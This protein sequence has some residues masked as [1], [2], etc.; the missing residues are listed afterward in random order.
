MQK[1]LAFFCLRCGV[2]AKPLRGSGALES[3]A[4]GQLMPEEAKRLVVV[5]HY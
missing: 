1:K 2:K 3:A 4:R 5:T